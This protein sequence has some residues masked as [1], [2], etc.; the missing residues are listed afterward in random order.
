MSVNG[1]DLKVRESGW[2]QDNMRVGDMKKDDQFM[3]FTVDDIFTE[4]N[5]K[6]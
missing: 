3:N 2:Y 6:T 1:I 4:P 5:P